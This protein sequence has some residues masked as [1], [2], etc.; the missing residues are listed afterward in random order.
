MYHECDIFT[1]EVKNLESIG[2]SRQTP[3]EGTM[4]TFQ[5]YRIY[6]FL[7]YRDHRNSDVGGWKEEK[8][9]KPY[10]TQEGAIDALKNIGCMDPFSWTGHRK[11]IG[12]IIRAEGVEGEMPT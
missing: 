2:A 3:W 12:C 9:G 5:V 1:T 4:A 6:A 7:V 11:L 8:F 10:A